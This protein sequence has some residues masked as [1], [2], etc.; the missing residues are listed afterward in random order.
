M[1]LMQNVSRKMAI[2]NKIHARYD[3]TALQLR[4]LMEIKEDQNI[5]P[6]KLAK[7]MSVTPA[8]VSSQLDI[9]ESH[10]LVTRERDTKDRR[11]VYISLTTKGYK[12]FQAFY[13]AKMNVIGKSLAVLTQADKKQLLKLLAKILS[14]LN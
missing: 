5:T 11:I 1:L 9:L 4:V 6:G 2:M 8:T 12:T 14:V 10:K 3:L 7:I 13:K